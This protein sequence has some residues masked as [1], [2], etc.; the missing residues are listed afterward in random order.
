MLGQDHGDAQ[1]V[2]EAQDGGQH[3]LGR[4]RVEG[5]GRLVEDQ[6]PRTGG[7][8]RADRD[9]LL[10]PAGEVA[11]RPAAEIG[12]PQQV[13]GLLDAGAHRRGWHGELLH[14]VRELLLDDVGHEAVDGILPDEADEIRELA[15]PVLPRIA[16][17]HDDPA[18]EGTA[19]EVRDKPV[20]RPQQRGLARARRSRD[21][22]QL[23]LGDLERHVV[24]GRPDGVRVRHADAIEHDHERTSAARGS[25]AGRRLASA[26]ARSGGRGAKTAGRAATSSPTVG[27]GGSWG[28]SIGARATWRLAGSSATPATTSASE[29]AAL[30]ITAH[31]AAI[32]RSGR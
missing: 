5:R 10:L 21:E 32:H 27:S 19:G 30:P 1:V 16:S 25:R 9:A 18:G 3:L 17:A 4:G 15:R 28:H 8:H 2:D 26:A 31:S 22:A 13:E 11:Q 6:D 29:A 12:D 23:A 24:D 14:G 7:E 20:D